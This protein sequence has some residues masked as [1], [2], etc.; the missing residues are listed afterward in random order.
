MPK[1]TLAEA[2]KE[3]LDERSMLRSQLATKDSLND[4]LKK[5][6]EVC[7]CLEQYVRI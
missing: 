5:E 4:E 7:K 2:F 3:L 6:I 1:Q